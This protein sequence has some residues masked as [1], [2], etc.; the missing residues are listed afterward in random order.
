MAHWWDNGQRTCPGVDRN[1]SEGSTPP[2]TLRSNEGLK[3]QDEF[4]VDVPEQNHT[5]RRQN[6]IKRPGSND[7]LH[8]TVRRL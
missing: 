3:T 2:T 6:E 8:G 5:R 4:I 1:S 7:A